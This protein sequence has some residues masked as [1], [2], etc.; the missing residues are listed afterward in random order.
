L[1]NSST[2][3][4]KF[5]NNGSMDKKRKISGRKVFAAFFWLVI[6]SAAGVIL[7]SANQ[8]YASRKVASVAIRIANESEHQ[9]VNEKMLREFLVDSREW[10]KN[11]ALGQLDLNKIEKQARSNPWIGDAQIFVDNADVLH[12]DVVQR[13]P[14]ARIINADDESYYIDANGLPMPLSLEYTASVPVFTGYPGSTSKGTDSSL[15]AQVLAMSHFI[16]TDT[17]WNAQIQQVQMVNGNEF[18]LVPTVGDHVIVFGDTS[19]LVNKFDRLY[20]FY[21]EALIRL[22]WNTYQTINVKFANQVVATRRD[23]AS[24]F[25]AQELPKPGPAIALARP[26]TV[27]PAPAIK[28]AAPTATPPAAVAPKPEAPK[29]KPATQDKPAAKPDHKPAA[30]SKP[31]QAKPDTKPKTTATKP[32]SKDNKP[33]TEKPKREEAKSSNTGTSKPKA[34]YPGN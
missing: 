33:K 8:H 24:K 12:I 15:Y 6:L 4:D 34:V 14:E 29:P 21:K 28:P 10:K 1:T 9:F 22:K 17:F 30:A 11:A 19:S 26:D 23:P 3:S 5:W 2:P 27:K 7:I 25:Q 20:A 13:I 32:G 18:E 16:R 31:A